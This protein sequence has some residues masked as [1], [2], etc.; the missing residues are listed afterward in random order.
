[1]TQRFVRPETAGSLTPGLEGSP[2]SFLHPQR[3][4]QPAARCLGQ[5]APTTPDGK[6]CTDEAVGKEE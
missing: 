1:M 3:F 6:G 2:R 5:S 4:Q